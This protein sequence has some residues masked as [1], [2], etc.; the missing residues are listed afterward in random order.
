MTTSVSQ[1]PHRS[2][3][4]AAFLSFIFPG[5]GQLY[6][7]RY[8]RA[9]ILAAIPLLGIAI[10][11]ALLLRNGL[12]D[13]GLWVGQTSVLGPL[14]IGNV[15]LLAYRAFASVDAYRLAIE[16][17]AASAVGIR[18]VGRINPIS[19][20]GL[21][22]IL[23]VLVSGHVIVGYWDLKFYNAARDIHTA[24]VFEATPTPEPPIGTA[25][26]EPSIT[27]PPQQTFEPPPTIKP[28][29]GTDRLNVL[30][31]GADN[32]A[33]LTDTMMVASIDPVTHHVAMFLFQRDSVGL[34]LPPKSNLSS[35]W[36][37]NFPWKLNEMY[38][39]AD[40]FKFPGGGVAALKQALG[41]YLFGSQSA[42]QY[43]VLV[44]FDGFKTVI[45]ALGGLTLNVPVPL[46]DDGFPGNDRDGR[47]LRLFVQAGIQHMDGEQALSYARSRKVIKPGGGESSLFTNTGPFNRLARQQMMLVA[48]EQ[49]ADVN[50]I[51]AH[52]SDLVD[53][54]SKTVHTDIPEGPDILGPMAQLSK[55]I[56]L[57]DITS[58][59][60]PLYPNVATARSM[61]KTALTP[62]ATPDEAQ[63]AID[64]NA[65]IIVEN[66]TLTSGQD[67]TLAT[68]LQKM[69]LNVQA[70]A[71][72]P[73]QLGGTLELLCVN[74]ADTEFP[75]T[76]AL[77]EK[78]L[79]LTGPPVS[80]TSAAVQLITDAN[81]SIQ[82]VIIT[83]TNTPTFTA[84][85][86]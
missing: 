83:G 24:F 60:L 6:E 78:T 5:L 47:H 81:Q 73:A 23:V 51:S 44:D 31:I 85:P 46:K 56:K 79:G 59:S 37:T 20:A 39:D 35:F 43:Y 40:R 82:F 7:R 26:A 54:L 33:G 41:W 30:L 74:G 77:L 69:G 1:P 65:P 4:S 22:M 70:S 36:G 75:A 48:L 80:D 66:G 67:T 62:G 18:R 57:D 28:W 17:A 55:T 38:K 3:F 86:H 76:F 68:Y 45:D 61:V 25:S 50:E 63:A 9:F 53:A 27:F 58:A 12:L 19:I 2:A 13:F 15:V 71:N 32:A 8:V 10:S 29:T 84:A 64:E 14:A 52:L 11:I 42:I 34:P 49:E 21:A 72:Q 16:P